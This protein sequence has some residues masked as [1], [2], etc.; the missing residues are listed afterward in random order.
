MDGKQIYKCLFIKNEYTMVIIKPFFANGPD[1]LKEG[2]E[3]LKKKNVPWIP[4]GYARDPSPARQQCTWAFIF[5]K[6][7]NKDYFEGILNVW[8]GTTERDYFRKA[9]RK[10]YFP[11]RW[12]D[13]LEELK[14]YALFLRAT[15]FFI[16]KIPFSDV[17]LVSSG[18]KFEKTNVRVHPELEYIGDDGKI[19]EIL[20]QNPQIKARK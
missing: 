10:K 3:H 13:Q 7:S 12:L 5:E 14:E 1:E 9:K 17:I 18:E 16:K 4:W 6:G 20:N 19:K 11:P 15:E 8:E 2:K